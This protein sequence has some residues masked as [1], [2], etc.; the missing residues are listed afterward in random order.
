MF[1]NIE[2]D[3]LRVLF[4][5]NFCF[6]LQMIDTSDRADDDDDDWSENVI[7]IVDLYVWE[8]GK[9]RLKQKCLLCEL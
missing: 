3:N 1:L 2:I 4:F 9:R 5:N 7:G 8:V 6:L